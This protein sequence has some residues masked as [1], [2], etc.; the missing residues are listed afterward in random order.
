MTD[1]LQVICRTCGIPLAW[2]EVLADGAVRWNRAE[3][4]APEPLEWRAPDVERHSGP[5][6]SGL[7][8]RCPD[9]GPRH[10]DA[11]DVA[12]AIAEHQRTPRTTPRLTA[13]PTARPAV[14]GRTGAI[15]IRA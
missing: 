12:R 1:D 13:Q 4:A 11:R 14:G 2:G 7:T 9:H 6:S 3:P 10:V 8:L 15:T 5:G